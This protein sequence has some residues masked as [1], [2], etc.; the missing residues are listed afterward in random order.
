MASI[1]RAEA[2]FA[3]LTEEAEQKRQ[4]TRSQPA[5]SW[6][7]AGA[8]DLAPIDGRPL[9][10]REV[11]DLFVAARAAS[12][13]TVKAVKAVRL[14]ADTTAT[15][16]AAIGEAIEEALLATNERLASFERA[17]SAEVEPDPAAAEWA[18]QTMDQLARTLRRATRN[19]SGGG[20]T[21]ER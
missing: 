4:E 13:R 18:A 11:R 6:S 5:P 2:L 16:L 15:D 8:G 9:T 10:D 14:L 17:L 19:G 12:E 7:T 1:A 20:S 3:S 21:R